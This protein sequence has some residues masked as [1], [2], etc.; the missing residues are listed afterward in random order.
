MKPNLRSSLAAF[1]LALTG[2]TQA[3]V[4]NPNTD[5]FSQAKYGVFIHFL[6]AGE[7]GLKQV[8]QFDVK[9][10]AGQLEEMGAGYLVLTLGQNSGYFN[11]PNAAYEGR[12]GYAPGERCATRDL[13]RDLSQALQPKGIRL[14]LYLPCQTPNQDRRAQAAFG[15]TQ[16]AQDQPIDLVFAEKW[17][18]VIQEWADRYG[19]KVSG[20]WFDGGYEHIRF[21]DAIADRYAAAVKHGNPKAIVTFN[22]G[23]KVMRW[24]KAEDYTA[25]ELNEP[26]QVIPAERWLQGSQWHAL[27]YLGDTWGR[28]NTRF[29]DEQWVEWGRKVAARRGV[30]TLDMGPN[31]DPAAG[32]V[33]QLASAQVKQVKAI[34]AALRQETN[35]AM[36]KRLKRA[37]SFFGIHFDFHAGPDCNEIGRN[38][39]P[40]MVE[41]IIEAAH[42]DY[43]QI[44]CKGHPGLSSYPTKAG[45]PAPGFV[46]DPLRVWREATARHGVALYMHYSGVWD[47]EAIRQ[48]PEW[49]AVNADGT[50]N[51]NAT[52]FFGPYA[53]RL[54]I[55]QLRELARE[56]GVDGA[57]VDGECWASVPDYSG[58]ALKAFRAATG[59]Q[60]IPRRPGEPHWHE[61]LQFNRE[62]FRNHLRHYLAEVKKTDPAMQL[63]SN[64][65]FTDHMPEAVGAPV[66]WI[67]GDFS[68]EDSVNSARFSGRY[69]AHQGKPWDL[70]AWS[71]TTTGERRNGSRQKSAVQL[72][73]E[74]A[75]VLAQGGGFQPYYNQRRDGS[76]PE[77]HLPVIAEVAKFCR[78]R[79][80]YCQGATPVPQIALLYSTASHYREINGLFNRDL[81]RISGTLQA[82]VESQQVVDVVS[83]HHLEG[84]M[85]DYP[86][87]VV[88]ECDYLEP[89][90]KQELVRYVENGGNLLLIGPQAASLF[91]AELGVSLEAARSEPR[92]LAWGD[93]LIPTWDETRTPQLEARAQAFGQLH[94]A[95]DRNSASQ[96]AASVAALGKGR[97]AATYFSVSR[98]YLG[99]RS[100]Q[101]RA[102]LN[103]LTHRL[104]PAPMVEVKGS[105]D[106]DVSVNRLPGKLAVNLVNTAGPHWDTKKP[107]SDSIVPV[108]PLEIAIR[109]SAQP[110]KITLQPAGQRLAFEYREGVARFTVPRL[111][112][113]SVIVVE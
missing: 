14:M 61:F 80:P 15:L 75:V 39:T 45:N 66:D 56:Y 67:S 83:E 20:W 48:H 28:R 71:F 5:W 86:L 11:S 90:F 96:P 34:Q 57:W 97:I 17:S 63:C 104:F 58:S 98:G 59:I 60:E 108:G 111:E 85:A 103:E 93:A 26:R 21:N 76:V 101:A 18:A 79:Q 69:L 1:L 31:Y 47:S 23:V 10:L 44:D 7:E 107:L 4:A 8:G 27:T 24:T 91:V 64:W 94:A 37:E 12:T 29:S 95:N 99:T 46:G 33:G 65:A 92:Y 100:P 52:S 77:E 55:P 38:T 22:P 72:E 87:I 81:S 109:T 112:I 41:R 51:R 43:L 50:T 49:A 82:L 32:P 19:D 42:P 113:H 35:A 54:L 102:F 3:D 84:R 30:F 73:R 88:A 62:A 74:A 36:P 105:S 13:P 40:A 89:A 106:V 2:S 53:D 25:G 9:A 16:G 68:P 70:M 6:P 110:A 78:A